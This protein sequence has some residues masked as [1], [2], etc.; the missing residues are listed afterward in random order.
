MSEKEQL[1]KI[2]EGWEKAIP[3]NLVQPVQKFVENASDGLIA[4]F[5]KKYEV[6][7]IDWGFSEGS[8]FVREIMHLIL[9]KMLKFDITGTENIDAA[10]KILADGG[11]DRLV[12]VANHVS[13]SDANIFATVFDDNFS[14]NG[15]GGDLA[16]IAGPKVF[17]HPVRKFA[18]MHFNS[19]LIAQSQTVATVP[20]AYP[21]R[22]IA[23]AAAKVVEDIKARVKIFLVFPEGKRSRDGKMDHFL[24]GV[25]R[26]ID[27]DENVLVQPVS[28]LGGEKLLPV[29]Q[30]VLHTADI[31]IN[32]GEAEYVSDII[33]KIGEAQGIKQVFMDYLGRKVAALHP[34]DLR[35]V[36]K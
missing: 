4:D 12:F 15:F 3:E 21:I 16:V 26:M 24:A 9:N 18:S 32:V 28:I 23:R 25:Y 30:G 20:V 2:L 34:E 33:N 27:T 29:S 5:L 19:L 36:Y 10:L 17:S 11:A 13:Y 22:V 31:R 6:A 7:G 14:K 8:V 35:G 1:Y